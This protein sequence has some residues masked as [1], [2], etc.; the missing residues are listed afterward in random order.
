[1]KRMFALTVGG[2]CHG[3]GITKQTGNAKNTLNFALRGI[4]SKVIPYGNAL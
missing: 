4:L 2:K 1:M 3:T